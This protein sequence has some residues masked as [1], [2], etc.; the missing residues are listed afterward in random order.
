ML[1]GAAQRASVARR[2]LLQELGQVTRSASYARVDCWMAL[3][4][5]ALL[6]V[7]LRPRN[8]LEW[9]RQL[10]RVRPWRYSLSPHDDFV[11]G[12]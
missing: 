1:S 11:S 2:T 8:A 9:E 10:F 12:A 7:L 5:P 3:R 4:I 6:I